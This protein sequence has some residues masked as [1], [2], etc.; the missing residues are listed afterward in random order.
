MN[1]LVG[2]G[3]GDR[4]HWVKVGVARVEVGVARVE[5]GVAGVDVRVAGVG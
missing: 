3:V 2:V 1:E 5:V 4:L